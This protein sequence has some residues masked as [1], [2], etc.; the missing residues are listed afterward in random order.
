MKKHAQIIVVLL[1]LVAV[2]FTSVTTY[3]DYSKVNYRNSDATWHTLLTMTAYAETPISEHHF[4]PIV[5][6]GGADNKGIAWGATLPDEDGN[7]YYTSFSPAGFVAPYLFCRVFHLGFTEQSL[8][9]FN[10][11]IL[12]LSLI[13]LIHLIMF[14]FDG[15][16]YKNLLALCAVMIYIFEPEVLHATGVTYWHQSLFQFF[17]LLQLMMFVHIE[18]KR[19]ANIGFIL[20][21]IFNPYLEWTGYVANAGFVLAFLLVGVVKKRKVAIRYAMSTIGATFLAGVLFVAHYLTKLNGKEFFETLM[22]RYSDRDYNGSAGVRELIRDYKISFYA[23]CYIVIAFAIA[24][25]VMKIFDS[26]KHRKKFRIGEGIYKRIIIAI[27][28]CVPLLENILM[29]QHALTYSYDRMKLVIP[30]CLFS[31][32]ALNQLLVRKKCVLS[33][34]GI[35]GIVLACIVNLYRYKNETLYMWDVPYRNSNISLAEKVAEYDDAVLGT[36]EVRGYCNLLFGRG[37]YEGITKDNVEELIKIA[38]DKGK[39]YAVVLELKDDYHG[40]W[41]L[42]G[43]DDA[44]VYDVQ[45]LANPVMLVP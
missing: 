45:D 20:L 34:A 22:N 1:A 39:R 23:M 18:T 29:M 13:V 9:I 43:V 16:K 19:Y 3:P 8:F 14:L 27:V 10:K 11:V 30:I 26:I 24:I 31:C 4:L 32:D 25:V 40:Q 2:V 5:S 15:S 28:V 38:Q 41:D 35:A 36:Q 37:V 6:L 33:T 12:I 7:Y 42:F 21:S 44:I 17:F